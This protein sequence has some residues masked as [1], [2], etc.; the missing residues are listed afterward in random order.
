[1]RISEHFIENLKRRRRAAGWTQEQLAQRIE[2]L[3][4]SGVTRNTVARLESDATR[5]ANLT[6]DEA[7]AISCALSTPLT[8]MMLPTGGGAERVEPVPGTSASSWRVFE[9]LRCEEPLDSD[10][11][12]RW[13]DAV[14]PFWSYDTVRDLQRQVHDAASRRFRVLAALADDAA[15]DRYDE[16]IT[17]SDGRDAKANWRAM[18]HLIQSTK[19]AGSAEWKAADEE[20]EQCLQAY[21]AALERLRLEGLDDLGLFAPGYEVDFRYSHQ[22]R[23]S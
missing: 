4:F 13:R 21:G 12:D 18:L 8:A 10:D 20:Y 15:L 19:V 9:W 22:R 2:E 3:G 17:A 14:G 1:M 7:V 6:L 5:A 23:R 11:L 16:A